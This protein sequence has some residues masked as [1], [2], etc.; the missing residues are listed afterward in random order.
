M[1]YVSIIIAVCLMCELFLATHLKQSEYK[2]FF[3][4]SILM[5]T[6]IAWFIDPV[7]GLKK[8]G[9]YIDLYRYYY[10]MNIFRADGFN[11]PDSKFMT[12]YSGMPLMK[13][14][15]FLISLIKWNNFFQCVCC[16]IAY[17]CFALALIKIE[18]YYKV[19]RKLLMVIYFL[20]LFV[21]DFSTVVGNARMPVGMSIFILIFVKDITGKQKKWKSMIGYIL[22]CLIHNIFIIFLVFRLMLEIASKYNFIV[23]CIVSFILASLLNIVG[24][25]NLNFGGA[26]VQLIVQKIAYYQREDVAEHV[27]T[28]FFLVSA[29]KYILCGYLLFKTRF[30]R[31]DE[32]EKLRKF[33]FIIISFGIGACWNFHLFTRISN[34][35]FIIDLLLFVFWVHE[36]EKANKIIYYKN[37]R[38]NL[39]Y[40][41]TYLIC[42]V[43]GMYLL[44]SHHYGMLYFR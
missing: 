39:K 4:I 7:A 42:I 18:E 11:C 10:D 8:H 35:V 20:F 29:L 13:I 1:P 43:N 22:L 14:F 44:L 6:I 15:V 17:G 19:N 31:L 36:R 27:D 3:L 9:A 28:L 38:I 25:V 12:P 37:N 40:A 30:N 33:G 32:V 26:Y 41:I 5:F 16:L 2:K 23:I 21:Y 34:F 24:Q